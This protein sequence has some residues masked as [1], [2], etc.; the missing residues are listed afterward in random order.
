GRELGEAR[1]VAHGLELHVGLGQQDQAA[2]LGGGGGGNEALLQSVQGGGGL[3]VHGVG[4]GDLV[5]GAGV[6]RVLLERLLQGADGLVGLADL[7]VG[8]PD[9]FINVPDLGRR[10]RQALGVDGQRFVVG[11]DGVL[12]AA[13][14]VLEVARGDLVE[15]RGI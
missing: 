6:H 15:H 1:Q 11:G 13:E 12:V 9:L 10:E 2:Q 4:Q 3:A 8:G 7:V 5:V 14:L